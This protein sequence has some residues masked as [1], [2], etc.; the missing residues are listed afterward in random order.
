MKIIITPETRQFFQFMKEHQID[1]SWKIYRSGFSRFYFWKGN[2]RNKPS[3]DSMIE[4]GHF[5]WVQT[6]H[7][8]KGER[9][10]RTSK[11]IN[12]EL[13]EQFRLKEQTL[14]SLLPQVKEA[15]SLYELVGA[16]QKV[17]QERKVML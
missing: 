13:L 10:R 17:Q 11:Q 8:I 7:I 2:W 1:H 9:K 12:A 6:H 16:S 15:N 3:L 14:H 5:L 4:A